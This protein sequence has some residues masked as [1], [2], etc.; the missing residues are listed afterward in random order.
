MLQIVKKKNVITITD[1]YV[2]SISSSIQSNIICSQISSKVLQALPE[3][4]NRKV[5]TTI[6]GL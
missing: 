6:L 2:V 3:T 5:S 4:T 1:E